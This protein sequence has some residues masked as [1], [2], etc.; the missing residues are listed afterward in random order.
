LK[1]FHVTQTF[2]LRVAAGALVAILPVGNALPG[3]S[4]LGETQSRQGW[5]QSLF[6]PGTDSPC[7][8]VADCKR[9]IAE[10]R[11]D[12]WWAVVQGEWRSIPDG[13]VLKTPRSIDGDAY[14]CSASTVSVS[15]PSEV[16]IYCFVPPN[17]A[18]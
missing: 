2:G 11:M 16:A 3:D 7:C 8:D 15:N 12:G 17:L 4:R 5:F 10:W 18:Y 14:V 6:Q 13:S 1:L 9:T